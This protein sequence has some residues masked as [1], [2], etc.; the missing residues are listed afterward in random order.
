M[1]LKGGNYAFIEREKYFIHK[2]PFM[3]VLVIPALHPYRKP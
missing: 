3:A 1:D 2:K